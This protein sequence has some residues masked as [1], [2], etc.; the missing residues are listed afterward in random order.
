MRCI[1][2]WIIGRK[3]DCIFVDLRMKAAV[4]AVRSKE[5]REAGERFRG[6]AAIEQFW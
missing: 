5:E 3:N 4:S 1:D 6:V 2:K